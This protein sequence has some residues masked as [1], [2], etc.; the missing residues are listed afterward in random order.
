MEE[1][2]VCELNKRKKAVF[3]LKISAILF[4]NLEL[5]L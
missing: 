2:L 5:T 4:G 1:I 3:I